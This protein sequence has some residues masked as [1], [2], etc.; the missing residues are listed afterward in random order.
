[1]IVMAIVVIDGMIRVLVLRVEVTEGDTVTGIEMTTDA[2]IEILVGLLRREIT[3]LEDID[4]DISSRSNPIHWSASAY[5][6]SGCLPPLPIL[7]IASAFAL[8][9][10]T[11]G[12]CSTF[13]FRF[14]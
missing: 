6:N 2:E 7:K 5:P 10:S 8:P 4:N 12:L 1:M 9:F 13:A 14:P 3:T 11:L